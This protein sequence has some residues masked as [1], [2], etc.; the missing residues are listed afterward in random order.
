MSRPSVLTA[1]VAKLE[2]GREQLQVPWSPSLGTR[3]SV[4][5]VS[6]SY[7]VSIPDSRC[8]GDDDDTRGTHSRSPSSLFLGHPPQRFPR[9]APLSP[10]TLVALFPTV[11]GKGTPS[12]VGEECCGWSREKEFSFGPPKVPVRDE[13]TPET[14]QGRYTV[15]T[16]RRWT[17]TRPESTRVHSLPPFPEVTD[18]SHV[19]WRGH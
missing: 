13:S 7:T 16:H 2:P 5:R 18:S 19:G 15:V 8:V 11:S 10:T 6:S 3:T 1:L 12:V 4:P 9:P 14:F 17:V